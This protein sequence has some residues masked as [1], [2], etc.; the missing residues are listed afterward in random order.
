MTTS[1]VVAVRPPTD[2]VIVVVPGPT[3]LATP[4][5]STV[6][7]AGSLEVQVAVVVRSAVGPSE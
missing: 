7:T 6:A 5:A 2:A 1:S 3:A 4:V